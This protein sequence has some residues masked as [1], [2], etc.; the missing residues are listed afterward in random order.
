MI[1]SP[2][3]H[4]SDAGP[5]AKP[6]ASRA[7]GIYVHWPFC[8]SKCPYC[9]FNSHVATEAVDGGLWADA[10]VR[11]FETLLTQHETLGAP[12]SIFFGGGTPSLMPPSGVAAI[13]DA[14]AKRCHLPADVEITL[15]ANP[16]SASLASL[17]GFRAA[18]I[19][20]LSL[21]VQSLDDASLRALG[22]PHDAATALAAINAARKC[23][24][25]VSFDLIYARPYQSL[26]LW[27]RE[28]TRALGRDVGHLSLYQLTIEAN[29][30]YA[31]WHSRG[32]LPLPD[33]ETILAQMQL[34]RD[35]CAEAGLPHYEISNHARAGEECRHNLLYWRY[36]FY[37]G[38][39][40][41]AHG[42][43]P[44]ADK[45]S[46]ERI[47]TEALADPARWLQ[48]VRRCGHGL[49][50]RHSLTPVQQAEERLLSGLR[51][52]E[53][54]DAAAFPARIVQRRDA[55]V[56]QGLLWHK[57]ER[58]GCTRRGERLLNHVLE[59]LLA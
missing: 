33:E 11:E 58:I 6:D 41:G 45:E 36:G 56:A 5:D 13:L 30:P 38:V 46:G 26:S 51:L 25:R 16:E 24:Q 43:L 40:P 39:G 22:R 17:Q 42:R 49:A 35:C 31:R 28:L 19:N 8:V 59:Q 14:I 50:K 18:G 9:D 34:A 20:R 4:I 53:G 47:A 44:G 29:T 15:E 57:R 23:F 2:P 21:G 7:F 32:K 12:S 10:L 27:R 54:V 48:Q 1:A 3:R 37:L 55:L 52:R